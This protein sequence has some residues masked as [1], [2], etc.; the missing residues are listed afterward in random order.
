M[1]LP[2]RLRTWIRASFR[3]R[4]FERSMQDEMQLHVDLYEADLRRR[5]VPDAEA[6]RRARAEFGSVAARTDECR[7]AVGLRL[8]DE[9][10]ADVR[11]AL[12]LLRQSPTFTFVALLSLG[13]GIGANT[14]IFSLVD[15]VLV[16]FL[17]VADPQ[18]LFFVDN[19]GG[20]SGGGSGPPYPC[21]EALR[22]HNRFLAGIAAFHEG[23]VKVTIDGTPEQVLGQYASGSYFDVLGVKAVHGRVL[24]PRDDSVFGRGGPDGAVA[25][26]S[27]AL[28]ARR[29]G[30]DPAVLGK[31]VQVGTDWVTIV[32][33]TPP[34]FFGLQ[35]GSPIDIT[36]PIMLQPNNLRSKHLWW[37]S[38]V[39]R[40]KPDASVAQAR[41]DLETLFDAYMNEI[42]MPREKRG[43]FSGIELVPADRGS[44][45]LRRDYAEPLLIIMAIVAL[46][47]LI[48]CANVANLLAARA[49]ARRNE[50]AV[51]LAIGASR[52]R[53][54]RQMLTEGA[55]LVS[56]GAA[57]GLLVA[58]WGVAFLLRILSGPGDG[59]RLQPR[60][61][62][63]AG[64]KKTIEYYRAQR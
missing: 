30:L 49:S 36:V 55:V 57:M 34:D 3:R 61:D 14:A 16:K 58:R 2:A 37:M 7:E 6:H 28:W 48:G 11:F 51:R 12:R 17:P 35:V 29:F 59:I 40:L 22:D 50:V 19:S 8:F 26:I 24:T 5:G 41:G 13:L 15:T 47:L 10:R 54:V 33:V 21:Y 4:D 38:V 31:A 64:L 1:R 39:G 20:K 32:G 62:L 18:H 23:P 63:R 53:L 42:G 25:V 9:L 44:N 46:V 52:S 60:F 45:G 43:Y 27:H 56:L